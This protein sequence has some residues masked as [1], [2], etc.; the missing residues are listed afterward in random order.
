MRPCD[1]ASSDGE[2]VKILGYKWETEPDLFSPGLGKLNLNKKIREMKKPNL[3][4]VNSRYDTDKLLQSITLTRKTMPDKVAEF[5]DPCGF[6]EPLKLQTKQA[7]LPLKG[8]EWE[9]KIPKLEQARWTDI[10]TTFVELNNIQMP[11]YCIS[12]SEELVSDAA[13]FAGGAVI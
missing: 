4:S 13:E 5:F 12:S 11:G 1:K 8:L 7:M 3:S 6:W 2:T 9:E 10:L